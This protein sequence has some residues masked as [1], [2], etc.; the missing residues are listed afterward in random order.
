MNLET[1]SKKIRE[2]KIKEE[3]FYEAFAVLV[4]SPELK[5]AERVVSELV[6]K[7]PVVIRLP[8]DIG[9]AANFLDRH[10]PGPPMG[11]P[12]ILPPGLPLEPRTELL[13]KRSFHDCD[14]IFLESLGGGR[15]SSGVFC[16]HAWLRKSIVGPRPLPFFIKFSEPDK[17]LS[18]RLNYE[19]FWDLRGIFDWRF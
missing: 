5:V 4:P 6:L 18:E 12:I 9:H 2:E 17:I 13:L 15:D 7:S 11:N 1:A 8:D 10:E 16:V 14:R 3:D 19:F